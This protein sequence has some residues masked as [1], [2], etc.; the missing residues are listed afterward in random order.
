[1]SPKQIK[2]QEN[3]AVMDVKIRDLCRSNIKE[4]LKKFKKEEDDQDDLNLDI[5]EEEQPAYGPKNDE[6]LTGNME[7]EIQEI[8]EEALK[9]KAFQEAM[10]PANS[11]K[12]LAAKAT[13][14]N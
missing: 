8:I 14:V 9:K 6:L 12:C 1:M 7:D 3:I 4:H 10:S 11:E 5:V 2:K 13:L